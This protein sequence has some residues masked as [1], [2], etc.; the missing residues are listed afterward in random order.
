[1]ADYAIIVDF[2][3]RADTR[4]Q[5]R[6][7][8]D[9]NALASVGSEPGCR[10]FDVLEPEGEDDRVVLYEIYRDRSAFEDHLK[11]AHYAA[12]DAAVADL[13]AHKAVTEFALVCEPTAHNPGEAGAPV[14]LIAE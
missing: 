7:L 6:R 9:A 12:F 5:F 3:L 14:Q 8:V 2:R 10:R 4:A 13:V 1:V 11:T